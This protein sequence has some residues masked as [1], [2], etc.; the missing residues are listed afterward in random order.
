MAAIEAGRLGRGLTLHGC[1]LRPRG[2]RIAVRREPRHVA[3]PVPLARGG[4]DGRWRLDEPYPQLAGA[5]IGALG[6]AGLAHYPDW[7]RAGVARETLVT[8]PAIWIEGRPAA[9]PLLQPDP[10]FRFRRVSVLPPP[11]AETILR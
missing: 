7:R 11:W 1:V 3:P 5:R 10:R 8:T 6:A 2:D 9:A 4:W